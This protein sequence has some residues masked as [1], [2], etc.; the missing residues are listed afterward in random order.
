MRAYPSAEEAW[1]ALVRS[2]LEDGSDVPG[3]HDPLSVGSGFGQVLRKTR[4]SLVAGFGI[5]DP[6]ARLIG[7]DT[8]RFRLDFAV[9]QTIWAL[10]GSDRIDGLLFYQPRGRAFSDDGLTLRSAIGRRIF[11]SPQGDQL[12]EAVRKICEDA[13][14]RRAYIQI[15]AP[16]DLFAASRDISC[17]G[18]LQLLARDG[19]LHAVGHMRS[20]SALTVLPYD[21]FLMTTLHELAAVLASLPLGRYWHVCNSAHV[22]HDEFSSATALVGEPTSVLG[23]M[24][25]MPSVAATEIEVLIE[26][27]TR[28]RR[29]LSE[30]PSQ[31]VKL[32]H[33]G[34]APYW[35]DLLLA[36][37]VAAR[38]RL[39]GQE[40]EDE[41]ERLPEFY[42]RV[43]PL[44]APAA[45]MAGG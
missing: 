41:L 11:R 33:D 3:V 16:D 12:R 8:R 32:A 18:S 30:N 17:T 9:A 10:S 21:L 1:K 14:T 28:I 43:L 27:E 37:T 35:Q 5:D 24:P 29:T 7:S 31:P 25:P 39:G 23:P 22:Y 19:A 4:E 44:T 6:R 2:V 40:Q 13:S 26:A 15:Y 38:I 45:R 36:L 34:L 42:R 20:Q